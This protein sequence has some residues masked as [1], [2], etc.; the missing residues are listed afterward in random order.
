MRLRSPFKP[1]AAIREPMGE[2]ARRYV[3]KLTPSERFE[4]GLALS[5]TLM[6][7]VTADIEEGPGTPEEK[8]RKAFRRLRSLGE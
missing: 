6:D 2:A 7:G 5:K 4:L 3:L 8:A 1:G